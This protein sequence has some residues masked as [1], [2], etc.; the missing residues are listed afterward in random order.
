MTTETRTHLFTKIQTVTQGSPVVTPTPTLSSPTLT[1]QPLLRLQWSTPRKSISPLRD[2]W[3]MPTLRDTES[4]N[5]AIILRSL[6]A[7]DTT[8]PTF[9]ALMD[10]LPQNTQT[11]TR[12][13]S[14][15]ALLGTALICQIQQVLEAVVMSL[16]VQTQ[17]IHLIAISMEPFRMSTQFSRT[18]ATLMSHTAPRTPHAERPSTFQTTSE[19]QSQQSP[20]SPST[21]QLI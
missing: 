2:P 5:Q 21:F 17:K 11:Q 15:G 4:S 20:M 6:S 1:Q 18:H 13:P 14:T 7:L 8:A 16:I 12:P 3:L 9:T 10:L 19:A